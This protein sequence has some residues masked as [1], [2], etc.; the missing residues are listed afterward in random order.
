[1]SQ[2]LT[3][4]DIEPGDIPFEPPP[5]HVYGE[6]ATPVCMMLAKKSGLNQR[7]LAFEVKSRI[8]RANRKLIARVDVAGP[9]YLNFHLEKPTFFKLL[10][11]SI[12]SLGEEW[13]RLES[14]RGLKVIVEHTSVN[15][16][17][18]IGIGHARN[19]FLGDSIA[20]LLKA[21][22][23]EVHKHFYIDDVGRQVS[24]LAYGYDL[25]GR[26]KAEGKPDRF[27]GFIYAAT[28]CILEVRRLKSELESCRSK[29]SDDEYR[30]LTSQLDD[31]VGVAAELR[32]RDEKLFDKLLESIEADRDPEASISEMNRSYEGYTDEGI[33][34]LIR[35]VV[36]LCLEG[37]KETL[38]RIGVEFDSW[39]WE[40]ELVWSGEV[41]RMLSMLRLTPYCR[42]V[43]SALVFDVAEAA[44]N[45]G[46][47]RYIGIDI[48]TPPLT[49]TRADG[50]TLY[51]TRD[52]AYAFRKLKQYDLSVTVIGVDQKLPQTQ[53]MI[54]LS[55]LGLERVF[56]RYKP[57]FY[58]LVKLPG[59]KM[60]SR[61][62]R[63]ITLDEVLDE[64]KIR[65]LTE[66]RKRS[67]NIDTEE[68]S[69]VAEAIAVGAVKYALISVSPEKDITFN[70][71]RVLN[72]EMNSGPF[73]QYA[74]AR[75][76][77]ILAKADVDYIDVDF[78]P[79]LLTDRLEEDLL[80]HISKYPEIV[81]S[82]SENLAVHTIAEY[83]NE[84]AMKFNTFYDKLPVL[85]A[86][87][88]ELKIARLKLVYA[89]K[90]TLASALRILGIKPL[91]RM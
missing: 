69:R 41:D 61:R 53:L 43:E 45:L 76:S 13:G 91:E 57:L 6:L 63:I 62:G 17:H 80:I 28:S 82:S 32:S 77:S 67:P 49:L 72:F 19:S 48:E 68:A 8:D 2:A 55:T 52:I 40:S 65:A 33:V 26:P 22:G 60:S 66:I 47:E 85:K 46:L 12:Q 23:Y 51:T 1:M 88:R 37:F 71:D 4:L 3:E 30:R 20:S 31:W 36:S 14:D 39:D 81:W 89:F 84:L 10:I 15:P 5:S 18:P 73:L 9:G 83:A 70:W 42:F 7:S 59:Y 64:A 87:P 38:S 54:A 75:A 21:R 86:E 44:R 50:T 29:Q 56:E 90:S 24:I 25:L 78:D 27:L 11:S 79:V 58:G 34:K 35:E 16:I 74:H